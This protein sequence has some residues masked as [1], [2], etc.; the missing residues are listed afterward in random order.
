VS[1]SGASATLD[2]AGAP[3]GSIT[4]SATCTDD[5]GLS[6]S[7]SAMVN[8]TVPPPP[9]Q[10]EKMSEC[11]F[12][13]KARPGRVDNTCKAVLD[14]VALRLQRD[15]DSRLVVVGQADA[16]ERKAAT[17]AKQRADNS[18]AY[19]VKEKGIDASRIETRA[20][21]EGGRRAEMVIVPPGASY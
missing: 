10:A 16:S 4:V 13:N 7:G 5:R 9:P 3:A 20:G 18:K 14:D 17:L 21:S 19:L 6:D 2:T 8:V 11:D 1:G 12:P 15:A